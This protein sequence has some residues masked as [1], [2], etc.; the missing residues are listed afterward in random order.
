MVEHSPISMKTRHLDEHN[1]IFKYKGN[2]GS[3][4]EG[5]LAV[6][7]MK[8]QICPISRNWLMHGRGVGQKVSAKNE[9][10]APA[11]TL[12]GSLASPNFSGVS[13]TSDGLVAA[14]ETVICACAQSSGSTK[15]RGS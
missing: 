6:H 10:F 3:V 8:M 12:T 11:E 13:P 1:R 4:V 2:T 9:I 5:R 14:A 15:F 7:L